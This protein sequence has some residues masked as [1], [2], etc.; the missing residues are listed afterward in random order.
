M[1]LICSKLDPVRGLLFFC[2]FI[3]FLTSGRMI[4]Q[5]KLYDDN[6]RFGGRRWQVL[7]VAVVIAAYAF[8]ASRQYLNTASPEIK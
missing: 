7:A 8:R 5:N 1:L 6:G 2:S 3:P 4:E